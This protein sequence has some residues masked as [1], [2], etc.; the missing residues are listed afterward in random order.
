MCKTKFLQMCIFSI[1]LTSLQSL[2]LSFPL[3]FY[4]ISTATPKSHFDSLNRHPDSPHFFYFNPDSLHFRSISCIPTLI[5]R[6]P[7]ILFPNSLFQL[8]QM[9]WSVCNL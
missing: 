1:N 4:V 2:N 9:P 6:I 3:L 7:L 8:L 5:L